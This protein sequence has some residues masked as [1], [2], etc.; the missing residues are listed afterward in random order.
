VAGHIGDLRSVRMHSFR[1]IMPALLL[2]PPTATSAKKTED[3][4]GNRHLCALR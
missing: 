1:N 4:A 3:V 2:L